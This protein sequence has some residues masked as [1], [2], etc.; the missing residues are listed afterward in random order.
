MAKQHCLQ[1]FKCENLHLQIFSL[2]NPPIM[3]NLQSLGKPAGSPH[4]RHE[5]TQ[6]IN[7]KVCYESCWSVHVN[8][9]IRQKFVAHY[10]LV[11]GKVVSAHYVTLSHPISDINMCTHHWNFPLVIFFLPDRSITSLHPYPWEQRNSVRCITYSFNH[12]MKF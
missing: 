3:A 9:Y 2:K 11:G 10:L 8:K 7:S 5:P 6:N 12:S 4:Y 1:I